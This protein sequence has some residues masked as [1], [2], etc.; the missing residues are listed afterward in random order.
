[1]QTT[2]ANTCEQPCSCSCVAVS[3]FFLLLWMYEKKEEILSAACIEEGNF[4][5]WLLR[6]KSKRTHT[7]MCEWMSTH[8]FGHTTIIADRASLQTRTSLAEWLKDR[9]CVSRSYSFVFFFLSLGLSFLFDWSMR[10]VTLWRSCNKRD[11]R[12]DQSNVSVM[13][14]VSQRCNQK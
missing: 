10:Y 12:F 14:I 7:C 6:F 11:G 3:Q 1:M 9:Y 2:I 8:A 13:I 5:F 4:L